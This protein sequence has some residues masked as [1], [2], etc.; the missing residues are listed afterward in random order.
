MGALLPTL[1]ADRK[2]QLDTSKSHEHFS[3]AANF[4]QWWRDVPGK[5]IPFSM[6]F[7]FDNAVYKNSFN[8]NIYGYNSDDFF[9]INGYV[10]D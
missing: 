1:S 7:T 3:T 9:P 5:N 8:P 2:P 4:N 6:N 10:L